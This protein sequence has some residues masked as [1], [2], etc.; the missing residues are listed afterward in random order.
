MQFEDG[1]V[2]GVDVVDGDEGK[3]A[4]AQYGGM[5]AATVGVLLR[6]R[7][8]QHRGDPAAEVER[9]RKA[10]AGRIAFEPVAYHARCPFGRPEQQRE[11]ELKRVKMPDHA[12][13]INRA[14]GD[15]KSVV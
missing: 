8:R 7:G 15:R 9:K 13:K 5:A 2:P 14:R 10:Y 1:T 3:P 6:K 4:L 11:E 12:P